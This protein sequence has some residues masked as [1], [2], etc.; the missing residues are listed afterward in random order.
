MKTT[1]IPG[2]VAIV[3]SAGIILA[4][5]G[6]C[7]VV[8][9][10]PLSEDQAFNQW[11]QQIPAIAVDVQNMGSAEKSIAA[12]TINAGRAELRKQGSELL[13]PGIILLVIGL[14]LSR[15]SL[16]SIHKT[17]QVSVGK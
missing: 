14:V 8:S 10:L 17:V 11:K 5:V 7:K 13:I 3:L 9:Y 15:L 4:V 2:V 16:A 12:T 1:V 6:A